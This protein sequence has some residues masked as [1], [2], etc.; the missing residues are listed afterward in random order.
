ML[1]W[2]GFRNPLPD[3]IHLLTLE[4]FPG[5]TLVPSKGESFLLRLEHFYEKGEDAVLSQP[6]TVDLG[7]N[8]THCAYHVHSVLSK[9][10][11]NEIHISVTVKI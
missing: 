10:L 9:S 11:M 8:S 5:P 1:Q 6:A 4:R 7:V 3:N 2:T